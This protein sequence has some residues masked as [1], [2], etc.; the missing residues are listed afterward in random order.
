MTKVYLGKD[1]ETG[2]RLYL[3][4][5]SWGCGWYWG[6]G[7]VGNK[8]LHFHFKS[9][10]EDSKC[11]KELLTTTKLTDDNWWVLRDLFKQAYALQKAAE[12]YR[13]GGHQTTV[14]GVTDILKSPSKVTALN[15]DLEKVLDTLWDYLTNICGEPI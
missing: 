11:C 15:K 5:H 2:E 8:D 7:Y 12:I 14:K 6:F 13:Y 4:K 1:K 10:I 9:Y 3:K